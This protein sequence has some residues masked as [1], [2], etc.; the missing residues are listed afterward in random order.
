M[1]ALLLLRRF[2]L[3][4]NFAASI[5]R[6]HFHIYIK[7]KLPYRSFLVSEENWFELYDAN[8]KA[9]Q[10][11]QSNALS[12][13]NSRKSEITF[14]YSSTIKAIEHTTPYP[15]TTR[16]A[17]AKPLTRS[18]YTHLV[19]SALSLILAP[20]NTHYQAHY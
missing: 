6:Y 20:S 17:S 4:T 12:P 16:S 14:S 10:D 19:S 3:D 9:P 7:P 5:G 18:P 1:T 11:K 2:Y 8:M 13:P 15:L